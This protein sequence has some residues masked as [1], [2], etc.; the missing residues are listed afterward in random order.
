MNNSKAFFI[1]YQNIIFGFVFSIIFILA[2]VS[3]RNYFPNSEIFYS[4]GVKLFTSNL[5]KMIIFFSFIPITI[6]AG[7]FYAIFCNKFNV[8]FYKKN[9]NSLNNINLNLL[10]GFCLIT[11]LGFINVNLNLLNYKI[12]LVL[13]T[14]FIFL[15]FLKTDTYKFINKKIF[16]YFLVLFI[17]FIYKYIYPELWSQDS[18]TWYYHIISNISFFQQG[19]NFIEADFYHPWFNIRG[20][21]VPLLWASV[22]DGSATR[23]ISIYCLFG[24]CLFLQDILK[25]TFKNLRNKSFD[26]LLILLSLLVLFTPVSFGEYQK[27][28][29]ITL[30]FLSGFYWFIIRF[31]GNSKFQLFNPIYLIIVATT[32]D[33]SYTVFYINLIFLF[34]IFSKNLVLNLNYIVRTLK[35]FFKIFIFSLITVVLLWSYNWFRSGLFDGYLWGTM[36]NFKNNYIFSNNFD[37]YLLRYWAYQFNFLNPS[38]NFLYF[39]LFY[40]INPKISYLIWLFFFLVMF[41]NKKF[42]KLIFDSKNS[43]TTLNYRMVNLILPLIIYLIA[44]LL[45]ITNLGE[46]NSLN[47]YHRFSIYFAYIS[48]V[49]MLLIYLEYFYKLNF[50]NLKKNIVKIILIILI[51][52]YATAIVVFDRKSDDRTYLPNNN[53]KKIRQIDF[54]FG[55]ISRADTV[56]TNRFDLK[57]CEKMEKLLPANAKVLMITYRNDCRGV[58]MKNINLF[59]HNYENIKLHING[60]PSN[61][62]KKLIESGFT[63]FIFDYLKE[64]EGKTTLTSADLSI[65]YKAFSNESLSKNFSIF[66]KEKGIL[67]L[68]SNNSSKNKLTKEDLLVIKSLQEKILDRFEGKTLKEFKN[69]N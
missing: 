43:T 38:P 30:F 54:F 51:P 10:T 62:Y 19:S 44:I 16:F 39:D 37:E 29:F 49:T 8:S 42:R 14:L 36:I 13:F 25:I 21:G 5:I 11:I 32:L 52:V 15:F 45:S 59:K 33:K 50:R 17:F 7:I 66:Y 20:N 31:I 3:L 22:T 24:S 53:L 35:P 57:F 26:F 2:C 27:F 60:T 23:M 65:F 63:H 12:T 9:K 41:V 34:L 40:I 64:S 6:G 18:Y 61:S 1:K 67:I 47:R 69:K 68:S 4:S 56:N 46:S 28:H 55:R 58:A 48:F